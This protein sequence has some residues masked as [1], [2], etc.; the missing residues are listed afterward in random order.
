MKK[1]FFYGLLAGLFAGCMISLAATLI[2]GRIFGR[3]EVPLQPDNTG[4]GVEA[5]RLLESDNFKAKYNN[6]LAQINKSFLNE[7]DIDA[8][9]IADGMYQGIIDSLGDKYADYYTAEEYSDYV[10]QYQG[11]YGGIG[12]YVAKNSETGDIVIVNPFKDA[13]AQRAGI[14]AG[15]ILLEIGGQSVVGKSLD[16]AVTLMKGKPGTSIHVKLLREK[17]EIELDVDREIVDVPTVSHTM[18]E[19]E[20]IGYIYVSAFDDITVKQFNDAINDLEKKNAKGLIIDV[21]DNGGGRLDTVV[22]MLNRILPEGLIMYTETKYGMDEKFEADD[23]ESYDKPI[24][25]LINGYSASA[26]EVFSGALKDHKRAT[27]VGTK[28]YGKGVVQTLF[29]LRTIG[30]GSA[31]KI[32]TA[33]Y[34]TPAGNNIDGIGIEPDIEVEYD[35]D[36]DV[37]VGKELRDNQL[38]KAIETIKKE[39]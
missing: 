21:R 31:I 18:L 20:E 23:K 12:A 28:S 39:L 38:Q 6:I 37:K 26:S 29:P 35:K 13:P 4:M 24:V 1:S 25:V 15:D 16:E 2:Y 27:L 14:K 30:D 33:K 10:E 22:A 3:S 34:F 8:D 11:Q 36:K 19:N 5:A 7:D 32:T 9:K 17:E